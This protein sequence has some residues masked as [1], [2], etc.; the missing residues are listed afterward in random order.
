MA[1]TQK[2]AFTFG[3]LTRCVEEGLSPDEI[4][5]RVKFA[6]AMEKAADGG[7]GD[8]VKGL[9]SS[10]WG[11]LGIGLPAAAAGL[12]AGGGYLA[13]KMRGETDLSPEDVKRQELINAYRRAA[14]QAR[15]EA[16]QPGREKE[17][18]PSG[19]SM[20]ELR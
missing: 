7:W 4:D 14:Q 1:L 5:E 9:G 20:F 3:F 2:E 8:V 11:L 6:H 16:S 15:T 12:G 17:K 10:A 18:K 19:P 13:A